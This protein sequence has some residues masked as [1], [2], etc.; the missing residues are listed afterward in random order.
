[1]KPMV[2]L[3][4]VFK[5]LKRG[6]GDQ[7]GSQIAI[8]CVFLERICVTHSRYKYMVWRLLS[9]STCGEENELCGD[10]KGRDFLSTV[11]Q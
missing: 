3:P 6:R 4:L 5:F 8:F 1:M 9:Q 7:L 10:L 11:F 2:D